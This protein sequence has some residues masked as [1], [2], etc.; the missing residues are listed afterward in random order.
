M[1]VNE[2][3]TLKAEN[4]YNSTSLKGVIFPER[5]NCPRIKGIY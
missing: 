5:N 3:G 4:G 1:K 2:E